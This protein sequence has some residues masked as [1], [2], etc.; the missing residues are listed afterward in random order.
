LITDHFEFDHIAD[1]GLAREAA[2]AHRLFN[3]VATSCIGQDLIARRVDI[4]EQI[5]FAGIGDINATYGNR[6]NLCAARFHRRT[7]LV[8]IP[9]L[10]GSHD[11]P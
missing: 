4:I 7:G 6:H 10:A 11:E 2:S 3:G 8:E 5:F 1:A 9:I